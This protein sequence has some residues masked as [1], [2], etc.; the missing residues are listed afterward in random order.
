MGG[1]EESAR[2]PGNGGGGLLFTMPSRTVMSS[3]A[4]S[5]LRRCL[6]TG[7]M[8]RPRSHAVRRGS[9][10]RRDRKK[11]SPSPGTSF[12]FTNGFRERTGGPPSGPHSRA[13]TR[14][15]G[16]CAGARCGAAHGATGRPEPS[17]QC[18]CATAVGTAHSA[19]S[20]G[21]AERQGGDGRQGRT[22]RG[23]V[24]RALP[25]GKRAQQPPLRH[26]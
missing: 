9:W 26:I 3:V 17:Y 21:R 2:R 11:C 1:V 8:A 24:H 19:A 7:G 16:S 10:V 15:R 14:A 6:A 22:E 23:R 25:G 4:R 5:R 20:A 18:L 12:P 13:S